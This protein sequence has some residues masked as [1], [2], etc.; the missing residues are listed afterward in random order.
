MLGLYVR[1]TVPRAEKEWITY[2]SVV[3]QA[4]YSGVYEGATWISVPNFSTSN[5]EF[6]A[7]LEGDDDDAIDYVAS[8][9]WARVGRGS[10]P[11]AA[12]ADMVRRLT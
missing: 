7:Y 10:S 8:P 2:P 5:Y 4:R 3:I 1:I 9:E 11:N 6:L 12:Y